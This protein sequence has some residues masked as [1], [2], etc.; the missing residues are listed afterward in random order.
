MG[1]PLRGGG[2]DR[3]P[4]GRMVT[5][6]LVVGRTRAHLPRIPRSSNLEQIRW[7]KFCF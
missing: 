3:P 7:Q 4:A 6:R 1:A 2:R 5:G